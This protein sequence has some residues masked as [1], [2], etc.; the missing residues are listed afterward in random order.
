MQRVLK[1]GFTDISIDLIYG[2]PTTSDATWDDNISRALDFGV[3]HVSAYALT[4]EPKTALAHQVKTGKVAAPSDER[5]ARQYNRLIE[6]LTLAGYEHYE[7][8]NFALPGH[9]SR[10]NT[11]YWQGKPYVG[12]GP[13]AHGFNGIGQ[14][15]W[16][17]ANNAIYTRQMEQVNSPSDFSAATGLYEV[18]DLSLAERYNEFVMTGLRTKWGISLADL[19]AR[20]GA[21]FRVYFKESIAP[22]IPLRG[23]EGGAK[24]CYFEVSALKHDKYVLTPAGRHHA[25]GIAAEAF[26]VVE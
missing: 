7:I 14:R 24:L 10:H 12:L 17:V 2:S 26:W 22:Y 18:E 15:R 11:A 25:D 16:N 1:A 5:F 3:P 21:E 9:Y 19:E 23:A 4:V 13:A 8:S 20:F 6:R